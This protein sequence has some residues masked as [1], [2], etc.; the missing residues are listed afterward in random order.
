MF[1]RRRLSLLLGALLGSWP[2]GQ[3]LA[4]STGGEASRRRLP[5][6]SE[7]SVTVY[8]AGWCGACKRLE[9]D[10]RDRQ[11]P[12]SLIDVDQNPSAHQRARQATGTSAIP[13]TC[14]DR[15]GGDVVWIVGADINAVE[16]A[17]RGR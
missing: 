5:S 11:I 16:R 2:L 9:Q 12:F 4:S 13:V 10:L 8:G 1:S 15:G 14:V 7:G 3:A 17:Y 6:S